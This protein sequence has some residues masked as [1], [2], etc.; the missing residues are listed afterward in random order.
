MPVSAARW[1]SA[2]VARSKVADSR[3]MVVPSVR[4]RVVDVEVVELAGRAVA[5][6]AGRVGGH[7]GGR[8]QLGQFGQVLGAHLL[9]DAVGAEGLHRPLHVDPRLV[10][11]VAERVAGVAADD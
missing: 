10:E 5:A 11:G 8:E 2:M 4:R 6:E 1:M 7:A 9:L 3:S